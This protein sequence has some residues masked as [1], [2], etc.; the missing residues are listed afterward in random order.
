[1][2]K[3]F[4]KPPTEKVHQIIARTALFVSVHGGQSEIVL[5]VKQGDNP[6]FGFLM[7]DH[8][9]HCYFR[10]LVS[11]P[12]LL[13]DAKKPEIVQEQKNKADSEENGNQSTQGVLSMIESI[14]GSGDDDNESDAVDGSNLTTSTNFTVT[15][16]PLQTADHAPISYSE[17]K[18]GVN[19]V[20]PAKDNKLSLRKNCSIVSISA[21]GMAQSKTRSGA[22]IDDISSKRHKGNTVEAGNLVV[23]PS[24]QL[25]DAINKVVEFI[26][27]NGKQFEE[28]LIKQDTAHG[29]F[30]FL[31]PNNL[32]HPYYLKILQEAY[33]SKTKARNL[34]DKEKHGSPRKIRTLRSSLE[35]EASTN[36]P[37]K[38]RSQ[39]EGLHDVESEDNFKVKIG[40]T[41]KDSQELPNEHAK[42]SGVTADVAA[43]I[44]MAA[45]RGLSSPPVLTA[46]QPGCEKNVTTILEIS[47]R[48]RNSSKHD[49]HKL[50]DEVKLHSDLCTKSQRTE[51]GDCKTSISASNGN[52]GTASLSF[53]GNQM[54]ENAISTS[55]VKF[56]NV[57]ARHAA[58]VATN[59]TDSSEASLTREQKLKAE[60]LKRA[61]LFAALIKNGENVKDK[62][63]PTVNMQSRHEPA[64]SD[65]GLAGSASDLTEMDK[66]SVPMDGKVNTM[67]KLAYTSAATK[68]ESSKDMPRLEDLAD[69]RKYQHVGS[70]SH[71]DQDDD[72]KNRKR[73]SS[74]HSKPHSSKDDDRHQKR[75][76]SHHQRNYRYHSSYDDDEWHPKSHRHDERLHKSHRHKT[77]YMK[78][79][80]IEL[81]D[82]VRSSISVPSRDIS[83][84]VTSSSQ[85]CQSRRESTVERGDLTDVSDELRAK[86]RAMLLATL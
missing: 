42:Q 66:E 32:Y 63:L 12:E 46:K 50:S 8:H 34:S 51:T 15:L 58:H 11:H 48:S 41:Q 44:V 10:F 54:T 16:P 31:L 39:F 64:A 61:K 18:T 25:K 83:G 1:M 76:K 74:A 24:T 2:L 84:R 81:Q 62:L 73:H 29:R 27:R 6:S 70:S 49:I 45:T 86:V 79:Q 14:Y 69:L 55:N 52:L 19:S 80:D 26:V 5:R 85:E 36:P 77:K 67:K 68:G 72:T 35:R 22:S 23:E 13:T 78:N 53:S 3:F 82:D 47:E 56:A 17:T 59:E 75:S 30:P 21:A 65:S 33:E 38:F 9:L 7:P 57:I 4:L 37:E 43:A 71:L 60:R 28:V 40:S 20:L